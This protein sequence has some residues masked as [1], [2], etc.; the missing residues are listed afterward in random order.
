MK[1]MYCSKMS[2]QK[3]I[4][5][6][7]IVLFF[8]AAVASLSA[9]SQT[10]HTLTI[11]STK[12]NSV[13][14]YIDDGDMTHHNG[15]PSLVIADWT[16]GGTLYH[17]RSFIKFDLSLMPSGA[18]IDSAFL[19]LYANPTS[20]SGNSGYPTWGTDNASIIYRV[21]A[22]WDTATLS[23]AS[24]PTYSTAHADTLSQSTGDTENYVKVDVTGMVHDMFS[25]G[26]N[27]GFMMK[28]IQE[29]TGLNSMIFYSQYVPS[30]DSLLTPKLVVKYTTLP[31]GNITLNSKDGPVEIFPNPATNMV[32]ITDRN[33]VINQVTVTNLLGQIVYDCAY[34][35]IS[36]QINFAHLQAG[37]Y[38]IKLNGAFAGKLRRE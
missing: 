10:V 37:L 2:N 25:S 14:T 30:A 19:S 29:T 12:A 20:L 26:G 8:A 16:A 17:W 24:Q 7:K 15:V 22:P 1:F 13:S 35:A 36:V 21:T 33:S 11:Q 9:I 28:H 27:L 5:M 38:F 6:K 31:S 34:N 4:H 3:K 23:W 18:T 32:T